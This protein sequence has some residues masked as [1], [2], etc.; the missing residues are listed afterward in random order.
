LRGIISGRC[1]ALHTRLRTGDR[2]AVAIQPAFA[3]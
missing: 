2:Y 3:Q 1:A